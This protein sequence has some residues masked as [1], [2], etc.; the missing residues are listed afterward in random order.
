MTT[1]KEQSEN[2]GF[3][4]GGSL[5]KETISSEAVIEDS[6]TNTPAE[7]FTEESLTKSSQVKPEEN[8]TNRRRTV[9]VSSAGGVRAGVITQ[10]DKIKSTD[11]EQEK[12]QNTAASTSLGNNAFVPKPSIMPGK[13]ETSGL[14]KKADPFQVASMENAGGSNRKKGLSLF[15]RMTGTGRGRKLK[16]QTA[17]VD[18]ELN[19][20]GKTTEEKLQ[21]EPT[22]EPTFKN[23]P[24]AAPQ[25][26]EMG[27]TEEDPLEIPA[28][29]RRQAN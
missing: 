23:M 11:A 27:S 24:K 10:K 28:F 5:N 7:A 25:V 8:N 20:S 2:K 9:P 6:E 1:D 29:L 16:E 4:Q 14:S 3:A 26:P 18:N 21:T 13:T 12:V 19:T 15:E 17:A 22:K